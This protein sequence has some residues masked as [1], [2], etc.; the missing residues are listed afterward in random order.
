MSYDKLNEEISQYQLSLF[1]PSEYVKEEFRP[2]YERQRVQNF[3][4]A[5]R[6]FFLIGM[7]K[8]N[9]LKRLESSVNSFAITMGRTV[10]KIKALEARIARFQQYEVENPEVDLGA[11]ELADVEDEE[12][13]EAL[14][15]GKG[16]VYKMAHLDLDRWL[17]DLERDRIQLEWLSKEAHKVPVKRDTSTVTMLCC[18]LKPSQIGQSYARSDSFRRFAEKAARVKV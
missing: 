6:E 17:R 10:E 7:M 2:S 18:W 3:T 5:Q 13:R 15:V 4:Q 9:F 16:L 12:L 14:E 1:R 11:V 8:V